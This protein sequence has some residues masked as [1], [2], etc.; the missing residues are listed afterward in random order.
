M[1]EGKINNC[2]FSRKFYFNEI[3]TEMHIGSK[4]EFRIF[5]L[6]ICKIKGKRDC[7]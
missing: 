2:R 4:K 5:V 1:R 7:V 3:I 6:L